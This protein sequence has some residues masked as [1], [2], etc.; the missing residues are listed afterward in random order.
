MAH[1]HLSAQLAQRTLKRQ[2][3]AVVKGVPKMKTG[4]IEGNIARSPTN[5]K[6]MAVVKSGGK[7]A[8]THYKTETTFADA[9]LL[10]CTL[11]TGRTHQIRVHL[12]HIGHPIIGDPVYGRKG[13]HYDFGRQALHAEKLTLVHPATE[14]VMEFLAPLPEDMNSLIS[15]LKSRGL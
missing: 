11:E 3:L 15:D 13:R 4:R 10:R 1:H 12:S 6:K 2:Y 7:T 8:V 9:A 14:E 5:R